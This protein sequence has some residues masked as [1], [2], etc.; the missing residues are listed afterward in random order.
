V[1]SS[2]G[3]RKRERRKGIEKDIQEAFKMSNFHN[4]PPAEFEAE[5]AS[6]LQV[7]HPLPSHKPN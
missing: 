1:V 7:L 6:M 4:Q 3:I 2:L 5:D